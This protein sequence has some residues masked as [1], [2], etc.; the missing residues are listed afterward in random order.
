MTD[1]KIGS[2]LSR[3]A[4]VA[5]RKAAPA[6]QLDHEPRITWPVVGKDFNL[7][8]ICRLAFRQYRGPDRRD[9]R[10]AGLD[11]NQA[12]A[13]SWD[14]SIAYR[15]WKTRHTIACQSPLSRDWRQPLML[16]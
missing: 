8:M 7:K 11:T 14:G 3:S 5:L 1:S 2:M 6:I 13:R 10:G 15:C 4:Y 9:S 16:R 12:R